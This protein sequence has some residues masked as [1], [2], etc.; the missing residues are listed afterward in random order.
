[1]LGALDPADRLTFRKLTG[2]AQD[3]LLSLELPPG[4]TPVVLFDSYYLCPAV[5]GPCQV[6]GWPFVSVAKKN[7]NF[8][9]GGRRW[10]P[11][12]SSNRGRP[13]LRFHGVTI[14]KR[15]RDPAVLI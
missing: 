13:R 10:T 2:L 15:S 5:A 8:Y 4:V 3:L 7:R 6:L 11:W 14:Q 12:L 1:M 9:P